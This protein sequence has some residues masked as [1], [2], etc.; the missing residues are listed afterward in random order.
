MFFLEAS[1]TPA[2]S[3]FNYKI[4]QEQVQISDPYCINSSSDIDSIKTFSFE[5]EL[6]CLENKIN[7]IDKKIATLRQLNNQI[8]SGQQST[9]KKKIIELQLHSLE[10]EK[11]ELIAKGQKIVDWF[12]LLWS[13]ICPS[14]NS[15]D[16]PTCSNSIDYRILNNYTLPILIIK[17][18]QIYDIHEE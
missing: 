7:D 17:H 3:S 16:S 4:V 14:L 18:Y 13:S 9:F 12:F 1:L 15:S 5:V 8:L 11:A 6:H 10:K 2:Y